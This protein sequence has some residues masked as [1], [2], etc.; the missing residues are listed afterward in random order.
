MDIRVSVGNPQL[1]IAWSNMIQR[2]T[3]P[4]HP[5]FA[6]YGARM[7]MP[8]QRWYEFENFLADM[9]EQP[10]GLTL[11]RIDN[12]KGYSKSNCRWIA[13][14]EQNSNR[15]SRYRDKTHCDQGHPL[16]GGNLFIR[17]LHGQIKG[18]GCRICHRER[19]RRSRLKATQH[20]T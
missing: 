4:N 16:S 6:D 5:R 9:G 15:R 2:C 3:N 20:K 1:I 18:R 11:D 13:K 7:I 10:E 19:V 12:D 8:V 17:K 14:G